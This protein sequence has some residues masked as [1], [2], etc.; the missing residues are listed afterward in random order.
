MQAFL[1]A[2][3][4]F[5]FPLTTLAQNNNKLLPVMKNG[6]FH[7]DPYQ[8]MSEKD[9]IKELKGMDV[10]LVQTLAKLTDRDVVYEPVSWKQHQADLRSGVRHF[11]AG[12]TYTEERAEYVYFSVPYRFE[13]NALFTARSDTSLFQFQNIADFLKLIKEKNLVLAVVDGFIYADPQINDFIKDPRNAHLIQKTNDDVESLELLKR[14]KVKG[15][16]ADRI[17]GASIIQKY[18]VGKLFTEVPLNIKT[19][20]HFMFSKKSVPAS[21][22]EEFNQA[23]S[24]YKQ[25]S[26]YKN[27]LS[28]YLAPAILLK[29]ID[30]KWFMILEI[31][32]TIA[33]AMS[34]VLI[35]FEKKSTLLG[36][37]LFA[38]LPSFGGGLTRDIIFGIEPVHVLR[39][40]YYFA[41]VI[42]V[43]LISY[44]ISLLAPQIVKKILEPTT[45]FKS[46]RENFYLVLSDGLGL[47]AFTI[48]GIFVTLLARVEPLWLWG[49]FFAFLTAVSG[50]ILRD[51]LARRDQIMALSGTLYGEWVF[52]WGGFF[53]YYI[54]KNAAVLSDQLITTGI[55]ITVAGVFI[56]RL[57]GYII[58]LRNL[59][60]K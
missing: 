60:F 31:I 42:G 2:L 23:I 39:T 10:T 40:P 22:V 21:V 35:A 37:F 20:I 16:L 27:T 28:W 3:L 46:R 5:F 43:V 13:E 30:S 25:T 26:E 32:G 52:L 4:V 11:A 12:A 58:N 41:C 59:F 56:S 7:W 45:I 50:G 51:I 47:A 24:S 57:L 1:F 44:L 33:F 53:S 34:G 38:F 15:F 48:S 17:V 55:F 18:R 36:A 14:G 9:G 54:Y 6:W 8:F 49:P 29:T 19:P